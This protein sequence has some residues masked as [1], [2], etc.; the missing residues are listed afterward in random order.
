MYLTILH[1]KFPKL[2]KAKIKEGIFI[3][4]QIRKLI[5]SLK[6]ENDLTDVEKNW[7]SIT[8]VIR[9]FLGNY[10]SKYYKR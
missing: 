10:K 1:I 7:F 5:N 3:G 9:N 6:F 4:P 2:S 8:N